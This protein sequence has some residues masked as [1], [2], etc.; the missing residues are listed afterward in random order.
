[1]SKLNK[2]IIRCPIKAR[3]FR[4]L[5]DGLEQPYEVTTSFPTTYGNI[6]QAIFVYHKSEVK[7]QLRRLGL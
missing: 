7:K 6:F 1:M 3:H 5:L 4:G 2:K